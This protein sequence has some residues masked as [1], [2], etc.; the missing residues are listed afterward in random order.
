MKNNALQTNIPSL[1]V[2]AAIEWALDVPAGYTILLMGDSGIGKS[3]I[4]VEVARRHPD[5]TIDDVIDLRTACLSDGD[6][7]GIPDLAAMEETGETS[8][9]PPAWLMRASRQPTILFLDELNRG[10]ISIQNQFFQLVYDGTLSIVR[11]GHSVALHP[12]TRVFA[13]VNVGNHYTGVSEMDL[14]LQRRFLPVNIVAD[15]EGWVNLYA[16]KPARAPEP[17]KIT[18]RIAR[19]E[20]SAFK[21]N[22]EVVET[23]MR[24]RY[25]DEEL[26]SQLEIAKIL[27]KQADAKVQAASAAQDRDLI[28]KAIADLEAANANLISAMQAH[29]APHAKDQIDVTYVWKD[30]YDHSRHDTRVDQIIIDFLMKHKD[31]FHSMESVMGSSGVNIF[32]NP[33]SWTR[34]SDNLRAA[35]MPLEENAG[36]NFSSNTKAH[37]IIMSFLGIGLGNELVQYVTNFVG[38]IHPTEYFF[39]KSEEAAKDNKN[40]ISKY[41]SNKEANSMGRCASFQRSYM[42]GFSKAIVERASK[43]AYIMTPE[44]FNDRLSHLR[45]IF[46]KDLGK[47]IFQMTVEKILQDPATKTALKKSGWEDKDIANSLR[48]CARLIVQDG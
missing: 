3:A 9:S 43:G 4:P 24:I 40:I 20:L 42:N 35:G 37:Q 39:A 34:L 10:Q 30:D 15:L 12:K 1:G 14:A 25:R 7:L 26:Q 44:Q 29:S 28:V 13:A 22:H 23:E 31:Q 46:P 32:P 33:A 41:Y 11:G 16:G 8:Y 36:K 47:T 19:N 2:S 45:E 6:T 18:T 38:T 17:R 48:L 5:Y 27:A 21:K